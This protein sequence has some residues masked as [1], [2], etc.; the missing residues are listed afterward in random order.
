MKYST[1]KNRTKECE[2]FSHSTYFQAATESY[3]IHPAANNTK[4]GAI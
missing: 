2:N 4:T 3:L 1:L